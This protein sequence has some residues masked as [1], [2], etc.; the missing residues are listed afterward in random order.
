MRIVVCIKQVPDTTNV[1]INPD[2]HTLIRENLP[3]CINPFDECAIEE[4]IR[5]KE[6]FGGE[7]IAITMGPKN[8]EKSLK[9]AI[10]IGVDRAILLTDKKFAGSDTLA[11]SYVLAAA[12][13]KIKSVDLCIFGK[14]AIDGDTAQVGPEV[15]VILGI[16]LLTYVIKI[17]EINRNKICVERLLEEGK[18]IVKTKL[19]ALITVVKGINKPRYPNLDGIKKSQLA[20]ISIWDS[21]IL[22]LDPNKVGLQGSPTKVIKI[23][24]PTKKF[25]GKIL[26][27]DINK[28]VSELAK[29]IQFCKETMK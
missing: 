20:K 16:P 10:S 23:Y 4:A 12:I 26:K 7:V 22:D 9:V 2:T 24:T 13:K 18:E 6:S 5:L 1:K 14:Q 11:T 25:K 21:K 17:K 29:K 28:I 15:S 19:P 8:A 3:V 27:G